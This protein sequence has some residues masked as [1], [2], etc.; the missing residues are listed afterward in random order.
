MTQAVTRAPEPTGCC[1]QVVCREITVNQSERST[2]RLPDGG[3]ARFPH[4][5]GLCVELQM[6]QIL[7]PD[8]VGFRSSGDAEARV[9]ADR[10]ELF[11]L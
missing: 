7:G 10:R 4:G 6:L 11:R 3:D 2:A 9:L 1:E 8:P 5:F